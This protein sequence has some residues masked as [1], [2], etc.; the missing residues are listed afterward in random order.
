M[1]TRPTETLQNQIYRNAANVDSGMVRRGMAASQDKNA[2][3]KMSLR[4]E[5]RKCEGSAK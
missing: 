5:E 2:R 4:Y 1:D 3:M